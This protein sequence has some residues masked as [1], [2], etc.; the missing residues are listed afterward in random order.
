MPLESSPGSAFALKTNLSNNATIIFHSSIVNVQVNTCPREYFQIAGLHFWW[1]GVSTPQI[2]KQ[3]PLIIEPN[4]PT[5][6]TKGIMAIGKFDKMLNFSYLYFFMPD[7]TGQP[8]LMCTLVL[9]WLSVFFFSNSGFTLEMCHCILLQAF[10][11]KIQKEITGCEIQCIH[12]SQG[13]P[14]VP[15]VKIVNSNTAARN[16]RSPKMYY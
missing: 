6:I 12:L 5:H 14:W 9:H 13:I 11:R 16:F 7:M 10:C 8:L 4:V 2:S 1:N 3:K 15:Q